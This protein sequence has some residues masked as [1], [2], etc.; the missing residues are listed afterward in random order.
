[1]RFVLALVL[2]G[3]FLSCRAG[4]TT[5]GESPT[6]ESASKAS[7][8]AGNNVANVERFGAPLQGAELHALADVLSEPARYVDRA[9][10]VTGI[11]RRVCLRKGCWMELATSREPDAVSCRVKFKD[12]GFFVP[13]DSAGSE[14]TLEGNLSLA[15][16]SPGRVRHLEREGAVFS[17]KNEDGSANEVQLTATGVE[18]VR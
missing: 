12:Y 18:L 15:R 7:E 1:M 14:I 10:R 8:G 2:C 4:S 6:P 11:S 13:T 5:K 9:L 17:S 3:S 16:V